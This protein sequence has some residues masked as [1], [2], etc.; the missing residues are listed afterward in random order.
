MCRTH[1]KGASQAGNSVLIVARY[2]V[3]VSRV[4]EVKV[5]I[6]EKGGRHLSHVQQPTSPS[7]GL[8]NDQIE[9]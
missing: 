7:K 3:Q 6:V 2:D 1:M 4:T 5:I 9:F 8:V